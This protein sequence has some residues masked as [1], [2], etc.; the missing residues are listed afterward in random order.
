MGRHKYNNYVQNTSISEEANNG[1]TDSEV[2]FSIHPGLISIGGR[3][4][5]EASAGERRGIVH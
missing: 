4:A 5:A 1:G 3:G 2:V